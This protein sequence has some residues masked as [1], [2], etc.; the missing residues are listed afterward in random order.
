MY[1]CALRF[2]RAVHAHLT[3]A[4]DVLVTALSNTRNAGPRRNAELRGTQVSR[5]VA[6]EDINLPM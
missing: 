5:S 4:R 1:Q 3:T 2:L 6:S